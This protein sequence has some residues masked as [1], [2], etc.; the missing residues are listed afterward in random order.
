MK[1]KVVEVECVSLKVKKM[2]NSAS[3]LKL[4][5]AYSVLIIQYL[6]SCLKRIHKEVVFSSMPSGIQFP[7]LGTA[8]YSVPASIFGSMFVC[9]QL[10]VLYSVS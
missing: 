8:L 3:P 6:V 2:M 4:N 9:P 5:E 10:D 1:K 7:I